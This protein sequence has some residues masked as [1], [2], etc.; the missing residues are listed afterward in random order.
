MDVVQTDGSIG[1]ERRAFL[2]AQDGPGVTGLGEDHDLTLGRLGVCL[3]EVGPTLP[4]ELPGDV[5][6]PG[7]ELLEHL[8]L[9]EVHLVQT[10]AGFG[11]FE[12][13]SRT[14]TLLVLQLGPGLG[15]VAVVQEGLALMIRRS[16]RMIVPERPERTL[17]CGPLR[18]PHACFVL[19]ELLEVFADALVAG[20]GF[21]LVGDLRRPGP[22]QRSGSGFALGELECQSL[23]LDRNQGSAHSCPPSAGLG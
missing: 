9:P 3:G 21:Q 16:F 17:R 7:G 8:V 23:D 18:R 11:G 6:V 20:G 22:R 4:G 14:W 12:G 13:L 1:L 2:L 5:A 15:N 19:D 10:A